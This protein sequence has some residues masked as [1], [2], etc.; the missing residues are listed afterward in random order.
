MA[1]DDLVDVIHTA[2]TQFDCILIGDFV[3]FVFW[4][5]AHTED[6]EEFLSYVGG[7]VFA[8][9]RV[10]PSYFSFSSFVFA[11]F[12]YFIILYVL[13]WAYEFWALSFWLFSLF[14]P[15]HFHFCCTSALAYIRSVSDRRC[16]F[17]CYLNISVL[18]EFVESRILMPFGRFRIIGVDGYFHNGCN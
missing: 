10:E 4:C 16:M 13:E 6:T 17:C 12:F 8:I 1:G 15:V 7:N 2:I 5:E 18:D 9:W 3:E 14:Y 11:D